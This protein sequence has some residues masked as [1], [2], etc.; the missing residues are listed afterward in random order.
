MDGTLVGSADKRVV[1]QL[2]NER[3]GGSAEVNKQRYLDYLAGRISY[4]QWVDLDVGQWLEVGATRD[5][6]AEVI[7]RDLRLMPGSRQTL[8]T[9]RRRGYRLAVISG[10]LDITLELLFPDHPF[11]VVYTNRIW[12]EDDGQIAGWEATPYDMEG[13]ARALRSICRQMDLPLERTAYIGDNVNDLKVMEAAGL[14]VAF[15]PKAE[16]VSEVADHTI[17]GDM[18]GLL[19]ILP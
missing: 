11:E 18:R 8:E 19:G 13:K 2:L 1:W 9:L 6:I 14:A 17:Q 15:E 12:F 3:F 10:T 5:E 7:A 4:P 16:E